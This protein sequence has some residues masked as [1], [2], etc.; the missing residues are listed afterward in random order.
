MTTN[1]AFCWCPNIT[2]LASSKRIHGVDNVMY[3]Y[4][5]VKEEKNCPL[6]LG[7][8]P[9]QGQSTYLLLWKLLAYKHSCSTH[10]DYICVVANIISWKC[11]HFYFLVYLGKLRWTWNTT[12]G[13]FKQLHFNIGITLCYYCITCLFSS[14][15]KTLGCLQHCSC[16]C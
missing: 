15:S 5:N 3:G 11:C 13:I 14:T 7:H 12:L 8:F 1:K 2:R 10:L 9:C 6:N 16:F 4:K